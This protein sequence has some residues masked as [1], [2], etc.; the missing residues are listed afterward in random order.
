[1]PKLKQFVADV[2]AGAHPSNAAQL[3]KR[4]ISLD[5]IREVCSPQVDPD[6]FTKFMQTLQP[7]QHQAPVVLVMIC[8]TRVVSE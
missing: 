4:A 3:I 5:G 8:S 6:E 7:P 2:F 1:M